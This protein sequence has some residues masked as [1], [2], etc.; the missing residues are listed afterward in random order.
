MVAD[1]SRNPDEE[2]NHQEDDMSK[3]DVIKELTL[4]DIPTSIREQI[5]KEYQAQ[6]DT[7]KRIAELERE[8]DEAKAE[9]DKANKAVAENL[10]REFELNLDEKVSELT[11]EWKV[12]GD[13]AKKKA[14][15]FRAMLRT[16]IVA[17]LGDNRTQ[18]ALKAASAR[19]WDV[20]KPIA[21]TV[22]SAMAGGPAR[23]AGRPLH[24]IK[25]TPE[26]RQAA[27]QRVGF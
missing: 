14:D 26:A 23:I 5:V 18:D 9:A 20:L 1:Q 12:E 6:S 22:V 21:E 19:A 2:N 25:D 8:R 7:E 24:Q 10:A 17:E 16:Q 15:A 27:R 3:E 13:E 4:G 11:K